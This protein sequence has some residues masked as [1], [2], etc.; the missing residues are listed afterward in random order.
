MHY[1]DTLGRVDPLDLLGAPDWVPR[2]GAMLSAPALAFFQS[3]VD[4][5]VA[6]R[7]KRHAVDAKEAC[8]DL[9]S[10]LLSV[11]KPGGG[12]MSDAEVASNIITF[13]GAGFETPTNAV[14]WALYLLSLA[15]DW[16]RRVEAEVDGARVSGCTVLDTDQLPS[17]RAHL[18][19]SLRL[20]PPV[21]I[22]TRRATADHVIEGHRIAAGATVIIAPWIVH[23]HRA[24]WEEPD[25][26][27]PERFLP[28]RQHSIG[29]CAYLPFGAGPRVCIGGTFAMQQ[30]LTLMAAIVRHFRLELVATHRVHPV[31]RVTLRPRGGM[32]MTLHRRACRA[33]R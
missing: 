23:R 10:V 16:R 32:L 12:R 5:I 11:G 26:F 27:V 21:A 31:H 25:E 22:I 8:A 3:V 15:P 9:V 33:R 1:F 30:M 29:R 24:L 18:Q 28:E 7:R 17:L 19:E 14:T 2:L 20:Y 4:A 6:A 13:I